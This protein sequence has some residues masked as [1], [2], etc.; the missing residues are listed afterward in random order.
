MNPSQG[1]GS[2]PTE[3]VQPQRVVGVAQNSDSGLAPERTDE[4]VSMSLPLNDKALSG[5]DLDV[6]QAQLV[7]LCEGLSHSIQT[8]HFAQ[9]MADQ[10]R[11]QSVADV[12]AATARY[13]AAHPGR[14]PGSDQGTGPHR[15][16]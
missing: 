2:G 7:S 9:Q 8:A 3:D 13:R 5:R 10:Q 15:L 16:P 11:L 4:V 12:A 14:D 1:E 6:V